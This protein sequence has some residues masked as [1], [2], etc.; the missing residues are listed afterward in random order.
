MLSQEIAFGL[1][2]IKDQSILESQVKFAS[3]L[4]KTVG[5]PLNDSFGDLAGLEY[6]NIDFDKPPE[7]T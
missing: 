1:E 4:F 5:F 3:S 6:D 2:L 7:T